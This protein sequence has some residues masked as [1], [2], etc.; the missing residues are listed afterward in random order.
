MILVIL[1]AFISLMVLVIIH[2]W[3]HFILARKFGVRVDEFGVGFPPRLFGKKIGD[4]L[5]SVNL[6]P[7]GAFV[8]IFGE[9][10]QENSPDSF[11]QKPIWQRSLIVL[12]GVITFW[13]TAAILLTVVM[14]LGANITVS[15]DENLKDPR[16]QVAQVASG[17]PAEIS[18]LMPGDIIRSIV[19]PE[20]DSEP[21]N[22][23]FPIDKVGQLQ[24]M[25]Q[26]YKGQ[27]LTL[28][29]ERGQESFKIE[30]M[31]RNNPPENEG[32]M[33]V[34]LLRTAIMSYPWYKAPLQG[35][36]ATGNMTIVIIV[37]WGRA[38]S[39]VFQGETSGVQVMG[40]VGIFSTFVQMSQLGAVYFLQF[41]A[42]ISVH[43]ALFN[44]LPIPVVDGGRF[45]FLMIE[46][47]RK[48]PFPPAIE[49]KINLAFFSLL[50]ALM[51]WITFRDVA[52]L[53]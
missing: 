26:Q 46:A 22:V 4:T 14:G 47:V 17:S 51:V 44:I 10:G 13:I 31:L 11:S 48:R 25:T 12:G 53:F 15:D 52:R 49:Q 39:G 42:L 41:I 5:Y 40:P 21:L 43:L 50:V 32:P 27:V 2:E 19:L 23:A 20:S 9:D 18:G 29:I 28:N 6:L 33:G 38:L 45:L 24:S 34:A 1:L 30:I 35:I 7:F 16:V 37:G 3:G 8:R 36:V